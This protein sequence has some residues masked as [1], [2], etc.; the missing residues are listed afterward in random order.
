M[1]FGLFDGRDNDE[2]NG[3]GSAKIYAIVAMQSSFIVGT[4][5]DLCC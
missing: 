2:H 5:L 3:V 4:E 1:E